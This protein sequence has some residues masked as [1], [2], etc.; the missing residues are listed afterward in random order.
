V[1]IL[2]VVY[3]EGLVGREQLRHLGNPGRSQ[4]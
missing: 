4:G 3:A 1:E 2:R